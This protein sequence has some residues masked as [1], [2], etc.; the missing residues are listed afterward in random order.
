[1][2]DGGAFLHLGEVELNWCE[3]C[4]QLPPLGQL[5]NLQT[6]HFTTAGSDESREGILGWPI[7]LLPLL[8]RPYVPRDEELVRVGSDTAHHCYYYYY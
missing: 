1:M 7:T 8:D 6:Y 2:G 3:N 4:T 5:P